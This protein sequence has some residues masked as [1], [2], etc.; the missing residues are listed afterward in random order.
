M[1]KVST[2]SSMLWRAK[3]SFAIASNGQYRE[4][5]HY[6][7]SIFGGGGKQSYIPVP[8]AVI[9]IVLPLP[10]VHDHHPCAKNA[11]ARSIY[12]SLTALNM[13]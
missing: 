6:N 11:S 4:P 9:C 1:V 8:S 10:K 5:P 2:T 7:L 12:T 3:S 13:S